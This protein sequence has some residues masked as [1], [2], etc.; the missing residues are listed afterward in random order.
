MP[1]SQRKPFTPLRRASPIL[2]VAAVAL[3]WAVVNLL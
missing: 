1:R 3:L 2:A